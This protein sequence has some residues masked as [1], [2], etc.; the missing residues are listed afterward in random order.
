MAIAYPLSVP[1]SL[2]VRT[3]SLRLKTATTMQ[4]S[5]FTGQQQVYEWPAAYW[6]ADLELAPRIRNGGAAIEAFLAALHGYTGTFLWGPVHATA[7]Q[8]STNTTGVTVSGGGTAGSKSLALA[9]VGAGKTLLAGDY[10]Q[11]GSGSTTRLHMVTQDATANGS[12]IATVDIEPPL[13]T[14]PSGGSAVTLLAPLGIWRLSSP[15]NGVEV[16]L[17]GVYTASLS[18]IEAL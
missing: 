6:V 5:A 14:S 15:E 8:G 3:L 13:R 11:L 16:S 18:A 12:G 1:A 7:P 17:G 4:Q 10:L 9:G 2:K